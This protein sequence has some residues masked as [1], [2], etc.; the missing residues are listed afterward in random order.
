MLPQ[1]VSALA[2]R[3]EVERELGQGGMA[4]VYLARDVKHDRYV[5]VKV[6]RPELGNSIGAER[7]LR[8]I[9]TAARLTHPNILPLHDSGEANGLLYYVMPYVRGESLRRRLDRERQLPVEDAIVI[10]KQ[11]ASA[12]DYAHEQGVVHRDIK[13]ENILIGGGGQAIVADFGLARALHSAASVPLTQSGLAV[14]TPA[15]MSPE[16]ASAEGIVDP[17]TDLYSLGCV[18]FEMIAG[19]PPFRGATIQALIAH[20]VASP[21]P[22]VCS[23]R[24]SCPPWVDEAVRRALA[25]A[26]ADR[27][28]TA[29][30]FVRVMEG[31][32]G[33]PTGDAPLIID[34]RKPRRRSQT[35]AGVGAL[36]LAVAG[37]AAFVAFKGGEPSRL[38]QAAV[39]VMPFAATSP[40]DEVT[41]AAAAF[42]RQLTSALAEWEGVQV[43]DEQVV[44][45]ALAERSEAIRTDGSI[46][47]A[48]ELGAGRLVR[49][50]LERVGDSVVVRATSY[51]VERGVPDRSREVTYAAASGPTREQLRAVASALLRERAE[52]PW[53]ASTD[54]RRPHLDAWLAYDAGRAALD[55]WNISGAA[56]RLREAVRLDPGHAQAQLWLAQVLTWEGDL[57]AHGDRRHAARQAAALSAALR[58]PDDAMADGLLELVEGR[59]PAA[60][61]TFKGVAAEHPGHFPGWYGIG[62]CNSRDS[63]VIKEAR[64]PSGYVFRG[65]YHSAANAYIRALETLPAARPTFVYERLS[66]ILGTQVNEQRSG[67]RVDGD[68]I[69]FRAYPALLGDTL[70]HV[71]YPVATLNVSKPEAARRSHARLLERNRQLLRGLFAQWVR[72]APGNHAAHEM[73]AGVLETLGEIGPGG[74]GQTSA[75]TAVRAARDL[76]VD[77]TRR[78]A[79]ASSEVRLLLKNEDFARAATL[80]DSLLAA[81]GNPDEAEAEV[82]IGLAALT[83]RLGRTSELLRLTSASTRAPAWEDGQPM[84]I[85]PVLAQR[86]AGSR[87]AALLGACTDSVRTLR[88]WVGSSL[89]SHVPHPPD[90]ARVRNALTWRPLSNAVPC[91]GPSA[92]TTVDANDRLLRL[93]QTLAIHGPSAARAAFDSLQTARRDLRPGDVSIDYTFHEAWVLAAAGDTAGAIDYLDKTLGALST[94]GTFLVSEPSQAAALVRA[95]ALRARLAGARGD[96]AAARRWAEAVVAVWGK[97]DPPLGSVVSEM[98]ALALMR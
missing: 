62:D 44:Q 90:R 84:S 7:F 82:L 65:S 22:S 70:A 32:S 28:R 53:T 72:V 36:A 39:V 35:I 52:L 59:Y 54:G 77:S 74:P 14:G 23:E 57:Q 16:Q 37:A 34:E 5:A 18:V 29:G 60:C 6:L 25:K 17:R 15:Y 98:R 8:E 26:P 69:R 91:L 79:L 56:D 21:P 92:V 94:L 97:A 55:T 12:L 30:E 4:V 66:D 38:D 1:L 80:A 3:Y 11:I 10:A 43:L 88:D 68:T 75:L 51:D 63:L 50:T 71:P 42:R 78:L 83:G 64:S 95:M 86:L 45:E 96:S 41:N 61:T 9:S 33:T 76:T 31:R 73:L 67:Y 49:G 40:G 85:P 46:R 87:A 58:P 93:Q 19:V 27:F 47:L 48:R 13:P 2:G 24:S 89:A 20:H 81:H